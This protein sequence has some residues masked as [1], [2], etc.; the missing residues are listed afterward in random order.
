MNLTFT[1]TIPKG[2]VHENKQRTYISIMGEKLICLFM[3]V[4]EQKN[5][6][7]IYNLL[8]FTYMHIVIQ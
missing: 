6:I 2:K 7:D 5:I 3:A 8:F 1:D 4:F